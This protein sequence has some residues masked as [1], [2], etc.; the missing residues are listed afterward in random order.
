MLDIFESAITSATKDVMTMMAATEVTA[1]PS[2]ELKDAKAL[3][4]VSVTIG[5]SGPTVKGVMVLHYNQAI[6]FKLVSGMMGMEFSEISEDVLDALGE[7]TNMICGNVKTNVVNAGV[8]EFN[9]SVPT[10]IVGQN[11]TT[12]IQIKTPSH[13]FPF[14]DDGDGVLNI[15]L[16]VKEVET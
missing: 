8:P 14:N 5:F 16:K 9:I 1:Q 13:V 11:Y 15:E 6:A 7:I 3:G 10:I 2:I 12:M 4:H